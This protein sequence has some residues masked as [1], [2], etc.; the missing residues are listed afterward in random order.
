MK[1]VISGYA[2][3]RLQKFLVSFGY[4]PVKKQL[5]Q[6]DG[7]ELLNIILPVP[8]RNH[9]KAVKKVKNILRKNGIKEILFEK[10]MK[11]KYID[12]FTADYHVPNG[13]NVMVSNLRDSISRLFKLYGFKKGKLRLAV[14][15]EH[16]TPGL[17][18][19]LRKNQDYFQFLVFQGYPTAEK[20]TVADSLYQDFG[21][22]VQFKDSLENISCDMVLFTGGVIETYG[23]D[24]KL[25]VNISGEQVRASVPVLQDCQ[26]ALPPGV[27]GLRCG[28]AE[29]AE[30]MGQNYPLKGFAWN[31]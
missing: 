4:F 31:S 5:I 8:E 22:A 9:E 2:A 26:L 23:P 12:E 29:L 7:V 17:I 16:Y 24:V 6:Q 10:D 13:Y 3:G 1:A 11:K 21:L 30:I 28:H 20:Q 19:I 15:G 25:I 14:A 27:S 18:D